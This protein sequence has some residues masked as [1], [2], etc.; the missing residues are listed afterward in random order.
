MEE[1][2][3]VNGYE[4]IYEVSNLGHV[5][6]LERYVCNGNGKVR[7]CPER[8]KTQT[9]TPDG[10]L[11]VKLSKDGKD[12]RRGVHTLVAEAFVPGRFDG[13]EVNHIDFDRK[14]NIPE[15]L[16]W[17]THGDNVRYSISAGRHYCNRDLTGENNPNYGNRKLGLIYQENPEYAI[18]KQSR[19]GVQNGRS[20]SV[21]MMDKNGVTHEFD[22]IRQCAAYLMENGFVRAKNLDGVGAHISAAAKNSVAYSGMRFE[23]M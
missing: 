20:I 18:E 4:G 6:S 15:N 16:E 9:E 22:Y 7:L 19:P 5:K 11:A 10:Y 14:N 2:R 3:P 12:V 13:A 8:I 21:R 23:L 1:W 17:T